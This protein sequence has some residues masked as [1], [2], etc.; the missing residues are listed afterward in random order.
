MS[1]PQPEPVPAPSAPDSLAQNLIQQLL[2]GPVRLD[3]RRFVIGH[4]R[5]IHVG[6]GD[7][8][9]RRRPKNLSRRGFAV[10]TEIKSR[11]R[12]GICVSPAVQDNS[13][14]V[15]GGIETRPREH[16]RKLLTNPALVFAEP[17]G[18]HFGTAH[19]ALLLRALPGM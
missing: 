6:K 5:K 12:A 4:S 8:S 15:A 3:N 18:D 9:E 17:S 10:F 11:S 7:S 19:V 1:A 14:D 13:G 2:H 16:F